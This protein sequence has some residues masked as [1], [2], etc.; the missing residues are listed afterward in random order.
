MSTF[1][2]RVLKPEHIPRHLWDPDHD[3]H[4]QRG[5]LCLPPPLVAAHLTVVS[6]DSVLSAIPL[7]SADDAPV[8]G[9]GDDE[10]RHHFVQAFDGSCARA[11]LALI[12]PKNEVVF[13]SNR[14]VKCLSGNSMIFTDAPCG[15]GAAFL[16]VLTTLAE[17]RKHNVLPREPLDVRLIGADISPL[18][19]DLAA[20]MLEEVRAALEDQAVFVDAS[21]SSWDVLNQYS[22]MNVIREITLACH[23]RNQKLLMVANFTG[24]LIKEGKYNAAEPQL[25]ELF[26][27]CSMPGG[28]A[29]WIESKSKNAV[30]PQ[31]GLFARVKRFFREHLPIFGSVEVD[32]A[33]PDSTAATEVKYR[34]S[35]NSD[36]SACARLAVLPILLE[37]QLGAQS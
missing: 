10:T 32:E 23:E 37:P 36:G 4:G 18:A 3:D 17:L 29:L 1:D 6:R 11:Q 21:F 7:R 14:L 2:K 28:S 33:A 26:R 20:Q 24:F 22:N 15:A 31:T 5:L 30:G 12:D 25:K 35:L 34:P 8:G 13:A 16:A 19:K 9:A 27:Y